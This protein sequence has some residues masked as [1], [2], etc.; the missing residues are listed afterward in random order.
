MAKA[1]G[2]RCLHLRSPTLANSGYPPKGFRLRLR[3]RAYVTMRR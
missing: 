3:I 1:N 2:S